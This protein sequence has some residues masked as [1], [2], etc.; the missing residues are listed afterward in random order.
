MQALKVGGFRVY[1][2]KNGNESKRARYNTVVNAVVN[3]VVL[4]L[5]ER[6]GSGLKDGR[7]YA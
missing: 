1:K 4:R 5:V 6:G 2:K 7:K 3:A